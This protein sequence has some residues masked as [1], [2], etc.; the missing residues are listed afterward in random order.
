LGPTRASDGDP[1]NQK[2]LEKTKQLIRI[3]KKP[4]IFIKMGLRGGFKPPKEIHQ[5]HKNSLS[6]SISCFKKI[7]KSRQTK[8]LFKFLIGDI[9]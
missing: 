7:L 8:K 6:C 3:L 1:F 5:K 9:F 4:F 2:L